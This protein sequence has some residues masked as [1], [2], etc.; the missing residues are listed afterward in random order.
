[1]LKRLHG[2]DFDGRRDPHVT[3]QTSERAWHLALWGIVVAYAAVEGVRALLPDLMPLP[4]AAALVTLLPFAFAV[5][6]GI[7]SYEF[8]DFAAFVAIC[9][10]VSNA[11]E[12]MSI[13]T[14]FPFGHYYYT[15]ILGPKLFLVPIQVFAAY[16]GM[17]Y[18]AWTLARAI[19]D[20]FY[21]RKSRWRVVTLPAVA[22]FAMVAWDLAADPLAS[23]VQQRW[24]WLNGGTYFGVP[25]V[26]FLGW[27]LT[28]YLY[29]QLFA[30]YLE[31]WGAAPKF[32]DRPGGFAMQPIMLY[33]ATAFYYVLALVH[34][35]NGTVADPVGVTWRLADIY[36]TAALIA[37]F[38]MGGFALIAA[39]R[40]AECYGDDE[41]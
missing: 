17:G 39:V 28:V 37:T 23:T 4:L 2:G 27:Y 38:V 11:M 32:L 41:T 19:L 14:G 18:V 3:H 24:I 35:P 1:M 16:F 8:K 36:G 5:A 40:V 20:D 25:L 15:G 7:K 13:L 30:L 10:V 34:A 31:R 22:A 26:N 12:N 21:G 33:V 9:F 29:F 6:H